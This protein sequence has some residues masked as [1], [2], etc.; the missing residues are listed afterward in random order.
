VEPF[1]DDA[2]IRRVSAEGVLIAAGG[3]A[4]LLQ[5][6]HPK[7]AAGVA[8][9]SDFQHQPIDRLRRTLWYMLGIVYGDSREMQDV[10]D[11]VNAVHRA[12]VGPGYS[13]N[14]PDLQVWVGATLYESTVMLYER[15]MGPLP[16]E[17]HGQLL[18]QYGTLATALG[19]CPSGKWP[20]DV[21]TF[22][23]YWD[24]MIATLKVSDQARRIAHDVL[25][26]ATIPVVLRAL[27]PLYRLVT[28]GL[29]PA[30]IRDGFGLAWPA[31]RQRRLDA[32]FAIL[33]R[34][35]PY[36]PTRVRHAGVS[37]YLRDLRRRRHAEAGL[38]TVR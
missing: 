28:V 26:P 13:A 18:R 6:A 22:R 38:L 34:T 27:A 4:I 1:A 21:E 12:V 36:V 8:E 16:T 20:A 33:R 24:G 3:R 5:V 32:G 17:R 2:L 15:V 11:M 37:L 23:A 7:V 35:Y 29:L 14:D 30:R 9:H 10:A 19:R 25:F 31:A